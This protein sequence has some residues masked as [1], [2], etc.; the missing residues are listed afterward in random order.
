[1]AN[2]IL[3]FFTYS[4]LPPHLQLVSKPFCDLAHRLHA[5]FMPSAELS[6][7]LRKLLEAKDATVRA[8]ILHERQAAQAMAGGEP[9]EVVEMVRAAF[10]QAFAPK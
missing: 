8:L 9:A 4:H 10:A 5:A 6:T 1:M 3:E 7:A 2:P